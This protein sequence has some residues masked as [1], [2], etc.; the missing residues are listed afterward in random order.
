MNSSIDECYIC[1]GSDS[2]IHMETNS[3]IIGSVYIDFAQL[4]LEV[5]QI[6]VNTKFISLS[7]LCQH[8]ICLILDERRVREQHDLCGLQGSTLAV[9]RNEAASIETP[10]PIGYQEVENY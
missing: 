5:L 8:Q 10:Q 6:K 3:L 9:L 1:S 2:L 7:N 4:I